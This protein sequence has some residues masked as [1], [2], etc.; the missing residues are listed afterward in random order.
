HQHDGKPLH[1]YKELA[2]LADVESSKQHRPN[3]ITVF[4]SFHLSVRLCRLQL[5][6]CFTKRC[7]CVSP[8]IYVKHLLPVFH[9]SLHHKE[10]PM[11]QFKRAVGDHPRI[12]EGAVYLTRLADCTKHRDLIRG[13]QLH[14]D[15]VK[16]GLL[17]INLSIGSSLVN[18]Y[19]KCGAAAKA[20]HV[21]DE[22]PV[23]NI[24]AWNA[25]IAGHAQHGHGE[26]AITS[27]ERM[28]HEGLSPDA[29]TFA[30]ILKAC[31]SIQAVQRGSEFHAEIARKGFLGNDVVLGNALVDMYAKCGV[32]TMAQQVFDDLPVRNVIS[33]TAIIG[34]YCQLDNG[35]EALCSFARMQNESVS[36]DRVTL[37]C[38]LKACGSIGAA[39][40]GKEVH[41]VISTDR[42]SRKDVM[43]GNALVDMY[44]KCGA[45]LAA[46]DAFCELSSR[47]IFSWTVLITGYCQCGHGEEAIKCFQQMKHEGFS[48][49][50]VT[51]ACIL[52]ACGN[53]GAAEEGRQIHDQL[54]REKLLGEDSVLSTALVDMYAKCGEL[55][56]A[57]QVFN[58]LLCKDVTTW[59][60][61]IT[62]YCQHGH[63]E[64]A[65]GCFQQ[66]T[67]EGFCPNA[68]TFA[69][70]LKAC[71]SMRKMEIGLDIHVE[72]SRKDFLGRENVLGSALIDMYANCGALGKAK[73]VFDRL[74]A[75]DTV[76]WTALIAV[77][78][79]HGHVKEAL[80]LF[81]EM[82]EEGLSPDAVTFAC[83]LK[84][85]GSTGAVKQGEFFFE[86]MKNYYGI[87]PTV[88]DLTCMVDLFGHAGCFDKAMAIIKRMPCLD[89]LPAWSAFLSA[90][91]KWG[92]VKLGKLAFDHVVRLDG[93]PAVAYI[94]LSNLYAAAGMREDADRTLTEAQQVYDKSLVRDV[95]SWNALISGFY[96]RG[97]YKEAFLCYERM[98]QEG[99]S[100]DVITFLCILKACGSRG[101]YEWGKKV[102]DDLGGI[103][104]SLGD[105]SVLGTAL[106]DMY[107]KCGEF[108]K[109][110][111]V[112]DK[113]PCHNIAS[114]N[115]LIAGYCQ[116]G[117]CEEAMSCF[118]QMGYEGLSY[119][120][121]TFSC[122]L[123]AC[124]TLGAAEMGEAIHAEVF[125]KGLLQEDI[126]L[127]NA[128]VD[129]YAKCGS[130]VKAQHVF[131]ELPFR[132]VVSWNA[133]ITGYGQQEDE[134]NVLR[135][136]AQMKHEG[137]TPDAVT[138]VF[139]LKACGSMGA[140]ER[141]K[142][143]HTEIAREG[144]LGNVSI[145]GS[146]LV[147]MYAN[148]GALVKAQEVFDKLSLQDLVS[149]TALIAGYC[150]HGYGEES[151]KCFEQMRCTG[152]SPDVV[153]LTCVLKAC[154]SL[155]AAE[156]GQMYIE[157]MRRGY[158]LAPVLEHHTCMVHLFGRTGHFEKAVSMI[159]KLSCS[160]YLPAW[161]S[162]LST[163]LQSGNMILGKLAFEHAIL[164]DKKS[165]VAY[166][167][168]S[169][170]YAA[171]AMH[172]DTKKLEAT[173]LDCVVRGAS[174]LLE[175][176]SLAEKVT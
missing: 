27:L 143:I 8:T 74:C 2:I 46:Y 140:V 28:Q 176:A 38:I 96:E 61:L 48:P 90:C 62:G 44:I 59:N 73:E 57:Q 52:N 43:L 39:D 88:E 152:L 133:L 136:Y 87:I 113:L 146:A 151:L 114:W 148:C 4:F 14:A 170:I 150:H 101:A 6:S 81:E 116:H 107:A 67:R 93:D 51:Y 153:T 89:Y 31:G 1:C 76:S 105:D 79:Q 55:F 41:A 111:K 60:A 69:C 40:K 103:K 118:E 167:S 137:I 12:Q 158:G 68:V 7:L 91:R 123:K 99:F 92:N 169:N 35:G 144:V 163:S 172:E 115:A 125:R 5:A 102:H 173:K 131:N 82:E 106:V 9:S 147:D 20:Q 165:A 24:V 45:L 157:T 36:P 98:K 149:W 54:V 53:I 139:V 100:P 56:K 70:V 22:L 75:R 66:M 134:G 124:G 122:I 119:D 145:L 15:I 108:K 26:L 160:R 97:C 63:E 130:L 10:V 132:N 47:N 42:S 159:D 83:L 126:V 16:S 65:L 71:G 168:M 30:C 58:E 19:G 171:G 95:A 162:L 175:S 3:D 174:E 21:I 138:F 18:L 166:V 121:R 127:G 72:I 23:Q 117:R 156:K 85:C 29:V 104:G 37:L 142:E 78:C 49:D 77:Y 17:E 154:S 64:E 135:S 11:C 33:W 141:G 34:G 110:E 25:L 161:F 164:L 128:L 120:S 32:L 109:A 112:F 50:A 86:Y 129:M 80:D 94:C 155:G 13:S 84:A